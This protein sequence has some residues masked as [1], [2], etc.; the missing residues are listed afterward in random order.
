MIHTISCYL[1]A[2]Y[3]YSHQII[4]HKSLFKVSMINDE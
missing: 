3:L 4:L 2:K 1:T